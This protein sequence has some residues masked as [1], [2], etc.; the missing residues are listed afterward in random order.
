MTDKIDMLIEQIQAHINN[1]TECTTGMQHNIPAPIEF[2]AIERIKVKQIIGEGIGQ[3]K[4]KYGSGIFKSI[5]PG[6][7]DQINRIQS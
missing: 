2:S 1:K 4:Q 3:V 6:I 5:D 7:D